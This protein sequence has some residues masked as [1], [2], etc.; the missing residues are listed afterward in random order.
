GGGAAGGGGDKRS[1]GLL[2]KSDEKHGR[3][4][5]IEQR[6][7]QKAAED[8]NRNRVQDFSSRLIGAEQQR[9]QR[10]AGGKRGHQHR[11]KPLQAASD[12][13]GSPEAFAF[14]QGKIDIVRN[15]Q[16][17]VAR[18]DAGERD[19]SD[20]GGYRKRLRRDIQCDDAADQSQ[21]NIGHD[22]QSENSRAIAAVEHEEDGRQRNER[23]RTDAQGRFLL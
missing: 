20:H 13:E 2:G 5:G 19:E 8:G 11:G 4:D 9:G 16:D 15:L 6:R 7:A 21:R 18:R 23:E 12:D 22:D 1:Q 3:E 14:A 17:D 10:K